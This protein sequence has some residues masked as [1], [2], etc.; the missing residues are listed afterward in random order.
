MGN[1]SPATMNALRA[2]FVEEPERQYLLE[3]GD[4][5][6][7]EH[8]IFEQSQWSDIGKENIANWLG[9][10]LMIIRDEL[11]S[12]HEWIDYI[13]KHVDLMTGKPKSVAARLD[14]QDAVQRAS[15]ALGVACLAH[16]NSRS[17]SL[18][19]C[20]S[21]DD[22]YT[23]QTNSDECVSGGQKQDAQWSQMFECPRRASHSH[24]AKANGTYDYEA[25]ASASRW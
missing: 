5:F 10:Q 3:T 24:N 19:T 2:K 6:L 11:N 15:G 4:A 22:L 18:S 14:W 13:G 12:K 8:R 9:A 7:L 21:L 16:M 20:A 23:R 25:A 1:S 17:D